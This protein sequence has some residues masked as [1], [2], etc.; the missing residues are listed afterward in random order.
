MEFKSLSDGVVQFDK[1]GY[2]TLSWSVVSFGLQVASNAKEAGIVILCSSAVIIEFVK[3][4]AQYEKWFRRSQ[5][6]QEFDSRLVEVYKAVLLLAIALDDYLRLWGPGSSSNH[7][8]LAV[9]TISES[10]AQAVYE[11]G[12]HAI[13][14]RGTEIDEAD[15]KVIIW[16]SCARLHSV[17][18][19]LLLASRCSV[20]E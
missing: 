15:T 19:D 9:L 3:R 7:Q 8:I 12:E 6:D 20:Q 10:Y 11:C 5:P 17:L 16:V 2:A 14:A 4:Y 1:S 18:T 13:L